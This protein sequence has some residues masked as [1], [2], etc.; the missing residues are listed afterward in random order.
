MTNIIDFKGMDKT[1]ADRLET[2][3][4]KTVDDLL[5]AGATP[6]DRERL[7]EMTQASSTQV[8]E[9][10]NHADLARINGIAVEFA[11]LLEK[12]GVNT[13]LELGTRRPDNLTK[14][15]THL[16]EKKQFVQQLPTESQVA[17]WIEQAKHLPTMV[18]Y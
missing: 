14:A 10:I 1:Y 6:T 15:M 8:L 2:A 16:N 13:V 7:V 17:D 9:W 5:K 18:S 3:N 12:T 4:I 11:Q